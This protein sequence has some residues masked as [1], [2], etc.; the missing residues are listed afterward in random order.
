MKNINKIA[1]PFV[2]AWVGQTFYDVL[3]DKNNRYHL[4][5]VEVVYCIH[6]ADVILQFM[7]EKG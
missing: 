2:K 1:G 6:M 7:K 4:I 5:N 3:E